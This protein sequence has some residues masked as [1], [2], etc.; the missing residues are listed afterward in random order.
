VAYYTGDDFKSAHR[1]SAGGMI[2]RE[3][4]GAH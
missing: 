4:W 2:H 1:L 3:S